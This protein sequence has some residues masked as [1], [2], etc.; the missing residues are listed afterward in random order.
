M[1]PNPGGTVSWRVTQPRTELV[2]DS[3]PDADLAE[4]AGLVPPPKSKRDVQDRLHWGS[5]RAMKAL[6]KWRE[7]GGPD[8]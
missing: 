3:V 1:T 8:E 5:D 2:R 7:L 4:L 6:A